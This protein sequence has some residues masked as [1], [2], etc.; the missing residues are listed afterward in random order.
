PGV[1]PEHRSLIFQRFARVDDAR[2]RGNGGTGLGLAI[3]ESI[4]E[5]HAARVQFSRSALGGLRVEL[6][7]PALPT[8]G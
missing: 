2:T 3:V 5:R 8:P 7:L 6:R 1:A 4:A